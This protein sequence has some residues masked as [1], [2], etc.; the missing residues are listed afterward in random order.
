M[1]GGRREAGAG[2]SGTAAA[3]GTESADVQVVQEVGEVAVVG[4]A[5]ASGRVAAEVT[6]RA[7]T[8]RT[9]PLSSRII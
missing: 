2:S 3:S 5:L 8:G 9:I 4:G 6:S 1:L 7:G